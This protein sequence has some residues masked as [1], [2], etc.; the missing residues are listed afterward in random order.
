MI[1]ISDVQW[2]EDGCGVTCNPL[3]CQTSANSLCVNTLYIGLLRARDC[4]DIA[5]R[6]PKLVHGQAYIVNVSDRY[7]NYNRW[8]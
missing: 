7:D 4:D 6:P 2:E 5:A 8:N 1:T 3:S